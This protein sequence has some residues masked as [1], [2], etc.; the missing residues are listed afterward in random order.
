MSLTYLVANANATSSKESR[1][2]VWLAGSSQH[3][4]VWHLQ[5]QVNLHCSVQLQLGNN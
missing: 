3:F 5:K 2:S 1:L 4:M